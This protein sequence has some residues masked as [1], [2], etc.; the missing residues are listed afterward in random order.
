[1]PR[2]LKFSALVPIVLAFVTTVGYLVLEWRVEDPLEVRLISVTGV[3]GVTTS[4][5]TYEVRNTSRFAVRVMDY[6]HSAHQDGEFQFL[7]SGLSHPMVLKSGEAMRC[8]VRLT[9]SLPAT[10][11]EE[12]TLNVF[13]T[14]P[15]D[16]WLAPLFDGIQEAYM[17]VRPGGPRLTPSGRR[18]LDTPVTKLRHGSLTPK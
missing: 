17:K 4:T 14:P 13:W 8:D 7:P 9:W 3:P 18:A 11:E 1:M 12:A 2:W 6:H 15:S 16:R 10:G 5:L